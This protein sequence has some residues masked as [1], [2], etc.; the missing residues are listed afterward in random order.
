MEIVNFVV[1]MATNNDTYVRCI[2]I[3]MCWLMLWSHCN[4]VASSDIEI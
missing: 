1:S 2:T 3:L 4:T